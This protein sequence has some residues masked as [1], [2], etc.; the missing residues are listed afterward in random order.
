MMQP[1]VAPPTK[2]YL[3]EKKSGGIAEIKH[4]GLKEKIPVIKHL[5][6]G[7]GDD[8]DLNGRA[9]IRGVLQKVDGGLKKIT[10]S[11]TDL[12]GDGLGGLLDNLLKKVYSFVK[13]NALELVKT[14]LRELVHCG[15]L[16]E[17]LEACAH[18]SG[19][20]YAAS[21]ADP[22]FSRRR[23]RPTPF[24]CQISRARVAASKA[25]HETP[26]RRASSTASPG[27]STA[28]SSRSSVPSRASSAASR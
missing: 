28:P 26:P 18:S 7:G 21:A 13:N 27:R 23:F 24:L 10:G 12:L 25:S 19:R 22:P 6:G 11:I 1:S 2:A 8:D 3:L 16:F 4:R 15:G 9:P 5:G 17:A 14:L 20:P